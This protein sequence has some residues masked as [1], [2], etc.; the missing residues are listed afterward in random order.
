MPVDDLLEALRQRHNGDMSA[1]LEE[2]DALRDRVRVY[3]T[4]SSDRYA[5]NVGKTVKEVRIYGAFAVCTGCGEVYPFSAFGV[6]VDKDGLMRNQPQ[7][8]PCRGVAWNRYEASKLDED[9]IAAK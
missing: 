6:L 1:L 4:R 7:C 2:L 9:D 8:K 3:E 5:R